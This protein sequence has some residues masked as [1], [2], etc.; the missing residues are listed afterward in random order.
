MRSL[1]AIS[2][3]LA[4]AACHSGPG[5]GL[6]G[7]SED[8]QPFHEIGETEVL[9]FGGN[10]PFW[11]GQVQGSALTYTTPEDPKGQAVEVKRF[12]GRGGISFSGTLNGAPFDLSISAT[13]CGDSMSDR[14]YPFSA[15]LSLGGETRHG[16]AWSDAH[17]F[18]GS[19]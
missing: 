17:P 6:P 18:T 3:L 19:E 1:F 14:V 13:P 4:L 2:G 9:Q 10:E 8:H 7:N 16:C 5:N 15:L 12:A 11:G